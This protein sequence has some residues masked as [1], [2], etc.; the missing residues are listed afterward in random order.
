MNIADGLQTTGSDR[1]SLIED[2]IR[3]TT[4]DQRPIGALGYA[5]SGSASPS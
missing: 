3:P 2:S 1:T 5:G 4:L